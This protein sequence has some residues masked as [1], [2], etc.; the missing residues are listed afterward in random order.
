MGE[1]QAR[2][3]AGVDQEQFGLSVAQRYRDYDVGDHAVRDANLGARDAVV[4]KYG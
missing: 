2:G 3:G 4:M 1:A